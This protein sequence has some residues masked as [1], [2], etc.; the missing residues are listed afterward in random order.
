ML[1]HIEMERHYKEQCFVVHIVM[2][3]I[4]VELRSYESNIIDYVYKLLGITIN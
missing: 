1:S 2:H 3:I 4:H